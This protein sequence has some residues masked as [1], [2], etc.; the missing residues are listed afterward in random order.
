MRGTRPLLGW[1]SFV[2]F[3]A[4]LSGGPVMAAGDKALGEYLSSECTACHQTSGRQVGGIPA[5][6]G[7]PA[8]QFIALMDAYRTRQRDNVVMQTI[9]ARLT[10]EELL[11]LAAYY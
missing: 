8:D 6:V 7:H 5:I 1:F 10:E 4:S 2:A 3:A 11:A 9:A